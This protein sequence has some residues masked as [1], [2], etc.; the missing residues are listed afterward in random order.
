MS[1]KA[2]R[3]LG[4]AQ[5]TVPSSTGF[6]SICNGSQSGSYLGII[7][8]VFSYSVACKITTWEGEDGSVSRC[9]A[10]VLTVVSLYILT[11]FRN[12]LQCIHRVGMPC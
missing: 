5:H 4:K 6:T 7:G 10:S 3:F 8:S 11:T 1:C 12:D 2:R 9:H